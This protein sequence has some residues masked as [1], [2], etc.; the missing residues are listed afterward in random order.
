MVLAIF[1]VRIVGV[2]LSYVRC[3]GLGGAGR[4]VVDGLGGADGIGVRRFEWCGR[5]RWCSRSE[6]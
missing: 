6:W 1:V 5:Y 4:W 3:D 2:G